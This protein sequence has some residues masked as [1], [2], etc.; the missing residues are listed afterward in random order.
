MTETE[1]TTDEFSVAFLPVYQNPYQH[2]LTAELERLGIRVLHLEDIPS[3]AWLVRNRRHVEVL[4]LH[5]LYG[6]YMHRYL[7]PYKW[8]A[9]IARILLARRLGYRIVWTAHNILPHR[10][11]VR[12]IHLL[13]RRLVMAQAAAVI[14]HCEYGGQEL[15]RRFPRKAPTYVVPIGSYRGVYPASTSRA[16]ARDRLGLNPEGFT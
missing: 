14:V 5:W 7:T 8:V 4:H 10:M 2:L 6:V 11:P 15:L 3:V 13:V 1:P 9:F 12:P 16:E